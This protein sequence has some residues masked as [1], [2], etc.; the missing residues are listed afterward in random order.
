MCYCV[1]VWVRFLFTVY[2]CMQSIS[3]YFFV[4]LLTLVEYIRARPQAVT[5]IVL[6]LFG[7]G[8]VAREKKKNVFHFDDTNNKNNKNNNKIKH[9]ILSTIMRKHTHKI[10]VLNSVYTRDFVYILS[11]V[12]NES[13][14]YSLFEIWN[15]MT[16][17]WLFVGRFIQLYGDS[18]RRWQHRVVFLRIA[19]ILLFY[20]KRKKN[21][22]I[23]V[24]VCFYTICA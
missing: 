11:M 16:T 12:L 17:K 20:T 14:F 19:H 18:I 10:C 6:S 7:S 2:F 22:I 24:C 9:D 1:C 3:W 13:F 5:F 15:I 8:I 23:A 21:N 4:C